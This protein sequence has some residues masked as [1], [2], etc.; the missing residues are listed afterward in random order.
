MLIFYSYS[1]EIQVGI[2]V[3]NA[4]PLALLE[5]LDRPFFCVRN[6]TSQKS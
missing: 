2:A 5:S 3:G 6:W 4:V 1:L